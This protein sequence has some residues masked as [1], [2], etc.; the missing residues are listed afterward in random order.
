MNSVRISTMKKNKLIYDAFHQ[1][2]KELKKQNKKLSPD[3]YEK[4][5]TA[6]KNYYLLKKFNFL[7][8]ADSE[9]TDP[10]KEKRYNKVLARYCNYYDLYEM[11]LNIDPQ[12]REVIDIKDELYSF[13]SD[14]KYENAKEELE[15]LIVVCRTSEIQAMQN[16][17]KTLVNWKQ[18]IIN[19]FIIIPAINKKMNNALIENRNK[20][21]KLLKHSS[22]GYRCW[23]RF[24]NRVLYVLNDDVSMRL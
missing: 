15:N 18:E 7:L 24:R 12:L 8:L 17:S 5:L 6:Y 20:T 22:N 13:Y 21:I 23:N 10:N 16:F 3:E 4:Y 2:K 1:K 14:C 11:I 19:S 9:L